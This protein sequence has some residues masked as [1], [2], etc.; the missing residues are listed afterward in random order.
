MQRRFCLHLDLKVA[1]LLLVLETYIS[2]LTISAR[3]LQIYN[4]WHRMLDNLQNE[5][6]LQ[7]HPVLLRWPPIVQIRAPHHHTFILFANFDRLPVRDYYHLGLVFLTASPPPIVPKL[8]T[9]LG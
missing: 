1:A 4:F 6:H 7:L 9:T 2:F 8:V 5:F 3:G